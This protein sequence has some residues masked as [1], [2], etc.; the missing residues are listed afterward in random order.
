MGAPALLFTGG[1]IWTG[2]PPTDAV[3]VDGGRIVALGSA[4]LE[5]RGAGTEVIQLGGATLLPGFRDGHVHVLDGGVESL[6]CDLTDAADVD[7]ILARVRAYDQ[8]HPGGDWLLGY[9]YPP[10]V[11]PAGVGHAVVLDLAVAHRPVA[12][13][14]GDHHMV[15][16]NTRALEV[17]G[18][19][20]FVGDPPRGM[21]VRD[22][23]GRPTGTLL[24]AAEELLEPH[25]P[26]RTAA[27]DRDG[28]G[29][30]MRRLSAAGIVFAQ[31]ASVPPERVPTYLEAAEEG[32]LSVDLDLALRVDPDHWRDQVEAFREARATVEDM[33]R[34][35]R[36][37]GVPGGELT[38]RT[39]KL[40]LDGV[41]EGGT[42]ALLD[43][44][45]DAPDSR[46]ILNWEPEELHAAASRFDRAGFELHMHAIGD[47][48]VRLALDTVEAVARGNPK[49]SRRPVT[50]H[51]H[52]VHPDD[53]GRFAALGVIANFE[54]L[55][56]QPNGVMVDLT[57]PRLGAAR[58]AW[59]YPI[60]SLLRSG[61]PVSFGSDWPVSS[62]V[63]LEGIAV[64]VSRQTARGEP[65]GGWNPS[66][67]IT[68]DEALRAYTAGTAAQAGGPAEGV[69]AVGEPADLV[70]V[71]ADLRYVPP[72][73]LSEIPVIGTWLAGRRV[74][75]ASP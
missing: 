39:V 58:S 72:R 29:E 27:R 10:E 57:E 25:L 6:A 61:A 38:C 34:R 35:R 26:A 63:P 31:E 22:R 2:G 46:G 73:A 36:A 42:G 15:W 60:G 41:I 70:A 53:R 56:A 11:L 14:S 75:P 65:A 3:A 13:W 1:R 5:A 48:A 21:I 54:P 49:R 12:L 69:I 37:D 71:G 47:A 9:S 33:A 40:F 66:E 20:A 17:A 7:D 43:P 64:A 59:Q 45:A 50:A 51:T 28:L 55:W 16:C 8:E 52:L 44:Y 24:E 32:R 62:P 68:L 23:E 74:F 19:D 30:G 18:I 67:R 4:A